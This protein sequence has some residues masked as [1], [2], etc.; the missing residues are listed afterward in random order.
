MRRVH[1]VTV[2]ASLLSNVLRNCGG[3]Q[4]LLGRV[5]DIESVEEKFGGGEV[6]R[7]QLHG[8][9]VGFLRNEGELV[10][11]EVASMSKFL[12][13][14]EIEFVYLLYTDTLVGDVCSRA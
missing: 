3:V 1:V 8:E 4:S 12:D 14:G 9:L 7:N 5:T 11:A 2:G 6:N 13:R 10:S